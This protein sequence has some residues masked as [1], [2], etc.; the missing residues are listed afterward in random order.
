VLNVGNVLI[1]D[2]IVAT[3]DPRIPFGGRKESGY[4]ATRGAE[5]LLEMT[6]AK[7]VTVQRSK[8]VRSYEVTGDQHRELFD[9]VILALHSQTIRQR[10]QGLAKAV[11][12]AM[13]LRQR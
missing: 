6:V 11:G 1:N 3:A 9:G 2:I 13:R 4:G 12:A 5:G 7:V 8:S 10:G